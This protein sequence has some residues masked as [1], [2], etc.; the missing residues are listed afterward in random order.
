MAFSLPHE[1]ATQQSPVVLGVGDFG[2]TAVIAAVPASHFSRSQ[3][4]R[5]D[6]CVVRLLA[7]ARAL[8]TRRAAAARHAAAARAAGGALL[9]RKVRRQGVGTSAVSL[10]AQGYGPCADVDVIV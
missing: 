9:L 10:A 1:A 6:E 2:V 7:H 8:G 3:P 4:T 5:P